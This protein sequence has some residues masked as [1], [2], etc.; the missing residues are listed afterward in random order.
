MM[1]NHYRIW[2]ALLAVVI[3]IISYPG[4]ASAQKIKV[5]KIKGNTAL[6]ESSIPLEEGQSYDLQTAA[7]SA[8]VNY[9]QAGFKS[10]KNSV[11]VGS[12]FSAIRG[13]SIQENR[14]AAQGRYGWN[15]STLEL[16]VIGEIS[17]IDVGGG[18]TSN[19]ILGSYIDYNLVPNR[20][21]K[22][23]VYGPFGLVGFGSRQFSGGGSTGLLNVNA[24]GFLSYFIAQGS[25]ALRAEAYL[26]HRQVSASNGQ[27][28][29][30]GI[31]SRGLLIFYF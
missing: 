20:D 18:A 14:F 24:G 25:T 9:S 16:G 17:S 19:F 6:I 1:K 30:T 2:P 11:T 23:L 15:F 26:D 5:K 22:A 29:L 27:T 8:D 31:G 10:R 28:A 3:A 7:I 12:E 13:D 4:F 21:G